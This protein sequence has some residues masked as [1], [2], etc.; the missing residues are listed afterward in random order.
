[1][2]SDN[3][4]VFINE[5]LQR[6]CEEEQITFTRSRPYKKNDQCFVEQKN[7]SVVRKTIGYRRYESASCPGTVSGHLCRLAFVC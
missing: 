3:D 2:D 4:G 1:M 7:W 5:T 6:Y